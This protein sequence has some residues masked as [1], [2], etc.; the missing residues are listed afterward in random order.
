MDM[1]DTDGRLAPFYLSTWA[2]AL[3]LIVGMACA[4]DLPSTMDAIVQRGTGGPSVLR[5]EHLPLPR[6]HVDQVL[7]HVDAAGVNPVGRTSCTR[8]NRSTL[9][10][11]RQK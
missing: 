4:V 6:P 8:A 10:S 3:C 2:G 7:V 1:G 11:V 9:F 5:L